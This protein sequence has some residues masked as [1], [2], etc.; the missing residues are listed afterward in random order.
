MKNFL[1]LLSLLLLSSLV[2]LP[3]GAAR[4]DLGEALIPLVVSGD[5]AAQDFRK[6]LT[7]IEAGITAM[8]EAD[9]AASAR[10]ELEEGVRRLQSVHEESWGRNHMAYDDR[11]GG[12][13]FAVAISLTE[14]ITETILALPEAAREFYRQEYRLS[15]ETLLERGL[16][17]KDVDSLVRTA[18]LYPLIETAPRAL[19]AAGDLCFELDQVTRAAAI[20]GR[21]PSFRPHVLEADRRSGSPEEQRLATAYTIRAGLIAARQG[22]AEERADIAP[23]LGRLAK[24]MEFDAWPPRAS[25]EKSY[26]PIP[27]TSG[28]LE[29]RT[30]SYFNQN[31]IRRSYSPEPPRYTAEP[32]FGPGWVSVATSRKLLRFHIDSGKQIGEVALAPDPDFDEDVRLIK[33]YAAGEGNV[34]VTS[35][36]S[37]MSDAEKYMG[38]D[39]KVEI[40][41][42]GL[43]GVRIGSDRAIWDT[44]RRQN[45]DPFLAEMSFNGKFAV[46]GG[47]LYALGWR[48]KGDID[49]FLICL[50]LHTGKRL[51]SAPIVGNQVEL[52]MFGEAAY[53]PVLGDVLVDGDAIFC[54]TNLGVISRVRASDGHVL[55]ATEYDAIEKRSLR[56]RRSRTPKRMSPV[57][58]RNEMLLTH[59]RLVVTPLDSR[60]M[61]VLD[62][63]DGRVLQDRTG[64]GFLV[65]AWEDHFV[66][67]WKNQI[68]TIPIRDIEST[69]GDHFSA[70]GEIRGRPALV[71]DGIV[72]A[73]ESGLYY[74]KL[75]RGTP[76]S[77]SAQK[78]S[79]FTPRHDPHGSHDEILDGTVVVLPDRILVTS[80]QW[81]SC[82]LRRPSSEVRHR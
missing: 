29:W 74:Q 3:T 15:A 76:L 73:T 69:R 13:E 19:L 68:E 23:N 59:G 55:W 60:E 7:R 25:D 62:P 49:V 53:E 17:E 37:D 71:E 9:G 20:W 72:Y 21:I 27:F 11:I 65:G 4:A 5:E 12:R 50:D 63:K 2:L 42:R 35:Y 40:P 78:I 26:P 66:L 46:E 18:Q 52:T 64:Y 30:L 8:E 28:R 45:K 51:W 22:T 58:E 34:L 39:I 1:P 14:R 67:A 79:T 36:V 16:A 81:I 38:F 44:V 48:K 61:Y 70:P 33:F 75:S 24:L 41:Q 32:A 77:S 31:H 6:A 47:R 57:W 43:K 10:F 56:R 54:S 80:S 82:F